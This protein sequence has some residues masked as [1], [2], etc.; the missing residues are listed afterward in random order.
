[1][2]KIT[3]IG[4]YAKLCHHTFNFVALAEWG[5]RASAFIFLPTK[6]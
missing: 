6:N 2:A 1:M 5:K 4:T 3:M